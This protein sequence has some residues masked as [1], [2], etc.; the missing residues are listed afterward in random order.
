MTQP[1]FNPNDPL[2]TA[3]YEALMKREGFHIPSFLTNDRPGL[4]GTGLAQPGEEKPMYNAPSQT[5]GWRWNNAGFWPKTVSPFDDPETIEKKKMA[6][7]MAQVL[8]ESI[9]EPSTET[10]PKYAQANTGVAND[11]TANGS[12]GPQAQYTP[13]T[14]FRSPNRGRRR[15]TGSKHDHLEISMMA[16]SRITVRL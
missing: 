10:Y 5:P 15:T 1:K 14:D 9:S 6:E 13:L 11:A 16:P 4:G 3:Y 8:E 12:T 2:H 7:A